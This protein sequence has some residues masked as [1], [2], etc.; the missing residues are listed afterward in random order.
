MKI[1]DINNQ[2]NINPIIKDSNKIQKEIQNNFSTKLSDLKGDSLQEK[3]TILLDEI[4]TQAEKI[5]KK[6]YLNNILKYKKLVKEFLNLTVNNSHK[7]KKENF[8]D[9]RGRHRIMSMVKLVDEEL[10]N[11]TKDF[12]KNEKDKL[13]ILNRLDEIKGMLL[14]IFM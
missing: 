10:E 3:L 8:L 5:E 1:T 9:R 14:D 11:L 4:N 13:K 12:L 6:F 7:F 2:N